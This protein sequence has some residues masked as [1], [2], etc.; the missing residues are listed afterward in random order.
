M[1]E[2]YGNCFLGMYICVSVTTLAAIY[3]YFFYPAHMH[4]GKVIGL[5]VC[6]SIITTKITRSQYLG[7]RSIRKHNESIEVGKKLTS[8]CLE[9]SGMAYKCHK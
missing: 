2:Y 7:T 3:F 6:L 8:V 4:G 5:S 1:Y 9:S